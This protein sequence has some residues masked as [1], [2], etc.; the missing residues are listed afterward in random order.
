VA[1]RGKLLAIASELVVVDSGGQDAVGVAIFLNPLLVSSLQKFEELL[2][3]NPTNRTLA[4]VTE[5]FCDLERL[6][7]LGQ[8]PGDGFSTLR[9]FCCAETAGGETGVIS[10]VVSM[11]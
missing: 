11:E 1:A 3:V 5:L 4:K 8:V 10:T 9:A 6:W 7:V 2:L